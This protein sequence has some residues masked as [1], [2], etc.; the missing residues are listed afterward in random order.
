MKKRILAA[1]LGAAFASMTVAGSASA[2]TYGY[3]TQ[4]KNGPVEWFV[5][6]ENGD[7]ATATEADVVV[8]VPD[9]SSVSGTDATGADAVAEVQSETEIRGIVAEK[10]SAYEV[11]I[12]NSEVLDDE[13][14]EKYHRVQMQEAVAYLEKFGISYDGDSDAIYYQGRKVR[15]LVDEQMEKGT[16][17]AIHMPEGEI[18]LYTVRGEDYQ[19]TGVRVAAQE[20]YDQ[21]TQQDLLAEQDL[22]ISYV[23]QGADAQAAQDYSI[24]FSTDGK[25]EWVSGDDGAMIEQDCEATY[26]EEAVDSYDQEAEREHQ[27]KVEEYEKFGLTAEDSAGGWLWN[28]KTVYCLMDEDGS[29]TQNG[30]ADKKIYILVTRKEDGSIDEV[31]EVTLEDILKEK[32]RSDAMSE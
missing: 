24:T 11:N 2:M 31:K 17:K 15:W 26:A 13:E 1:L 25:A 23:L 10:P 30:S 18:D 9:G 32:I 21:K 12:S 29:F 27:R 28:G 16:S 19:L 5:T 7:A 4:G 3:H 8:T 22:E 20:E 14:L 6:E